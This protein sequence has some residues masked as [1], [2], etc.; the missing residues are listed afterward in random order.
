MKISPVPGRALH[1]GRF[2]DDEP[3]V[4]GMRGEHVSSL[5]AL[6][7]AGD[8]KFSLQHSHGQGGVLYVNRHDLL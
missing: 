8:A 7:R 2:G 5:H 6:D 3:G 4:A 1:L